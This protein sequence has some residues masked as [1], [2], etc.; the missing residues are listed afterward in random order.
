M[1]ELYIPG[2]ERV[3]EGIASDNSKSEEVEQ[4][5]DLGQRKTSNVWI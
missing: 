3:E 2:G 5:V 1:H 4:C